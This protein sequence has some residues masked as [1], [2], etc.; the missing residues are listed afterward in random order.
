MSGEKYE[1][2]ADCEEVCVGHFI[3][4][5]S[6]K[7]MAQA[8]KMSETMVHDTIVGAWAVGI[9]EYFMNRYVQEVPEAMSVAMKLS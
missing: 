6:V 1:Y 4:H 5:R 7:Q 9:S 3:S 8:F 2:V